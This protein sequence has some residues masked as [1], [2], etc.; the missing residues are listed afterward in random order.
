M[1][2][3]VADSF[4]TALLRCSIIALRPENLSLM[5]VSLNPACKKGLSLAVE[6]KAAEMNVH[7]DN[8]DGKVAGTVPTMR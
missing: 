1:Q 5:F 4:L 2:C 7:S 3:A 6:P 8:K